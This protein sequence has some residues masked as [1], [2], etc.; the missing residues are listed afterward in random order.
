VL[1]SHGGSFAESFWG[2]VFDRV[3]LPIFD[4][5]RAEVTDTTTFTSERRRAQEDAWLY[6]TC[7]HCLQVCGRG[8]VG[9]GRVDWGAGWQVC[10]HLLQPCRCSCEVRARS[11]L[12]VPPTH[13]RT[14]PSTQHLVDLFGQFHALMS[15]LLP[16]LLLLLRGFIARSHTSLASVGVAA[17]VRLVHSCG[18]QLD[19][20]GWREVS[21]ELRA[22]PQ[23]VELS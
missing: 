9:W 12:L 19:A 13:P 22:W 8:G 17:Y 18:S 14:H 23:L 3:L 20:Q 15:H 2:R 21:C 5:V 7:T 4:H 11:P 16:Q 6:E 1:Q 10:R